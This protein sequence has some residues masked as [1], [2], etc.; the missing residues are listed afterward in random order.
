MAVQAVQQILGCKLLSWIKKYILTVYNH[1]N[2][3]EQTQMG[4]NKHTDKEATHKEYKR[5][6]L[7]TNQKKLL[8][9]LEKF[10]LHVSI[11][12]NFKTK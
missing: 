6:K 1:V 11:Q 7:N 9:L 3:P 10:Y 4:S 8:W 5:L 2:L 12:K